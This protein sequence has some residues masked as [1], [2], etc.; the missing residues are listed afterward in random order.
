MDRRVY[1]GS[2]SQATL[3]TAVALKE[4][5]DF[6]Q[7]S[8]ESIINSLAVAGG[9]VRAY[10][11]SGTVQAQSVPNMTVK[12][13]PFVVFE[14][15]ASDNL[16][17]LGFNPNLAGQTNAAI[18][19]DGLNAAC[20]VTIAAASGANPRRD[21][22]VFQVQE[23]EM[24]YSANNTT[25]ISYKAVNPSTGAASTPTEFK[26]NIVQRVAIKYVQGTA[27]AS[28]TLPS[29][30]AGW[31]ALAEIYVPTSAASITSSNIFFALPMASRG[32]TLG[33]VNNFTNQFVPYSLGSGL[34]LNVGG[35]S[36][37]VGLN[38]YAVA[39]ATLTLTDAAT[40][41]VYL[42]A[43]GAIASQT[44]S[45]PADSI[46][47]AT[48]VTSGGN[49]T[50]INDK[51]AWM[52]ASSTGSSSTADSLPRPKR[53][54]QGLNVEFLSTTTLRVTPGECRSSDDTENMKVDAALTINAAS[55][56]ANGI[57]TG[58]LTANT[59]YRVYIIKNTG[60]GTVAAI[61]ST[62]ANVA[63]LVATLPSGYT[64]ARKLPIAILTN[65]SGSIRRFISTSGERPEV[66]FADINLTENSAG[67]TTLLNGGAATSFTDVACNSFVPPADI[68]TIGI[69]RL[70]NY[71]DPV[72][73]IY[74][75]WFR[76]KGDSGNG[77]QI[78][79]FRENY[80]L[81]TET[82]YLETDGSANQ[83]VQYKNEN[84][85]QL[86][87]I[88]AIGFVVNEVED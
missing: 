33:D 78:A 40:N 80:K 69:F 77:I 50:T 21:L 66:R 13:N 35:G 25:T 2:P 1:P 37:R 9:E 55:V 71:S 86:A 41:Y 84:A 63:A 64:K 28:P 18:T 11:T 14:R 65:S 10:A 60:S 73:A 39:P 5:V 31:T 87:Y 70:V 32:L 3:L 58:S 81:K 8:D 59:W 36:V 62:A 54:K 30:P 79:A 56:G 85:S 57:D 6:A 23:I 76:R 15:G 67:D 12:V 19:G 34:S 61:L 43:L 75:T 49:I 38:I 17:G 74:Q 20:N 45:F 52:A 72:A 88:H 47:I 48:V 82:H 7:N 44:G 24:N 27:A 16:H 83:Y 53:F 4:Q 29:V 26:P 46:P 22:I 68:S 51:R 42:T